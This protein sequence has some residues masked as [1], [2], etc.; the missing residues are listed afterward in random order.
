MMRERYAMDLERMREEHIISILETNEKAICFSPFL[1]I[2]PLLERWVEGFGTMRHVEKAFP[3]YSS[4]RY[5]LVGV[6]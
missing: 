4:A 3:S 2:P 5:K 1:V 6:L